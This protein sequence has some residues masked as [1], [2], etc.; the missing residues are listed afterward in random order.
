MKIQEEAEEKNENRYNGRFIDDKLITYKR[1]FIQASDIIILI[2][3]W[4]RIYSHKNI[5]VRYDDDDTDNA[6]AVV[7]API[8][9]I[10]ELFSRSEF[11]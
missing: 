1:H 11:Q 7:A 3:E 5:I 4:L 2:G 10:H 6:S 9:F 8:I